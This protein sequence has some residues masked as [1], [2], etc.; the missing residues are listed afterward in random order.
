MHAT[1]IVTISAPPWLAALAF[2]TVGIYV[3]LSFDRQTLIYSLSTLPRMLLAVLAMIAGCALLSVA[4]CMLLPG[5][6]PLTAYLAVNPGGIDAAVIIA[7]NTDVSLP[8]I[9]AAQ[10]VRLLL[11]IAA[12]PTLAKWIAN[13]QLRQSKQ[14]S[15]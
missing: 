4:F 1:G 9:L 15:D 7:S 2:G 11:V 14:T 6:D 5:T 8:V 13:R 10:F 12:A 3:G